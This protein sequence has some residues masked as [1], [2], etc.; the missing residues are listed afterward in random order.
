[1][2]LLC[3]VPG[4]FV[5]GQ[6]TQSVT[7]A[8]GPRRF[9]P[10]DEMMASRVGLLL[11]YPML[12]C[13]PSSRLSAES[14]WGSPRSVGS[15]SAQRLWGSPRSVG[16]RSAQRLVPAEDVVLPKCVNELKHNTLPT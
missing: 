8:P 3:C 6:S 11:T 7:L 12:L 4:Q 1:M 14:L 15:R 16:S 5:N 10:G 2:D 13:S 9:I